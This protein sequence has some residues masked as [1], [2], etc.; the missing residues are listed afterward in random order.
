[1]VGTVCMCNTVLS[2]E[3]GAQTKFAGLAKQADSE[4]WPVS[5]KYFPAA[6]TLHSA[7]PL[8]PLYVPGAHAAQG[9]PCGPVKP[10]R[11]WQ[12]ATVLLPAAES[13]CAGHAWHVDSA[14]APTAAE[15]LPAPHLVHV[16]SAVAPTAAEYLPAPHLV[17][18][19]DDVAPVNDEY[20]PASQSEH[21]ELP[22]TALYLPATQISHHSPPGPV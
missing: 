14:V 1:M 3:P 20:L 8:T 4:V 19:V 2:G 21:A 12:F 15:Y 10:R 11:Q 6:H 13:E 7:E 16:D 18:F 17:Q 22:F 9:P 5:G